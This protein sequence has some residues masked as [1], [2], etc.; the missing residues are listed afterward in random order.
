MEREEGFREKV[1]FKREMRDIHARVCVWRD[2]IPR[3]QFV[4]YAESD[5]ADSRKQR[6][7][8]QASNASFLR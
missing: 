6:E 5:A 2:I 3:I 1:S 8:T 4:Q 7:S